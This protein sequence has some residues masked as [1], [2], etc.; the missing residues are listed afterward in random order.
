[1]NG[2]LRVF[3]KIIGALV[4]MFVIAMILVMCVFFA[5]NPRHLGNWFRPSPPASTQNPL[6][7]PQAEQINTT[8]DNNDMQRQVFYRVT[9]QPADVL[10]F[11]ERT[12]LNDGWQ[13]DEDLS[14]RDE[15]AYFFW[16]TGCPVYSLDV[17]TISMSDHTAVT[18]KLHKSLCQ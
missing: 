8:A 17:R 18:L 5:Y 12:L 9:A 10:D 7:Y 6:L 15:R 16:V 11:Y 4:S 14:R 1:M 13:K 2:P 3:L